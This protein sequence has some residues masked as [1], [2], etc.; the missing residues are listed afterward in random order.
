MTRPNRDSHRL[1][2]RLLIAWVVIKAVMKLVGHPVFL[3]EGIRFDKRQADLY[4]QGRTTPGRIVTWAKPGQSSHQPK[5]DGYA[6]ALDLAFRGKDTWADADPW[7]WDLVG[8][9][10]RALGLSWGGN[11]RGKKKDRPHLYIA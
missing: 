6:W 3:T 8:L 11:W 2:P 5:S 4:A 9:L 7:L 1:H 10:A